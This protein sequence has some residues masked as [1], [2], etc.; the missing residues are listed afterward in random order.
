[1]LRYEQKIFS[2]DDFIFSCFCLKHFCDKYGVHGSRFGEYFASSRNHPKGTGIHQESL[3]RHV[4]IGGWGVLNREIVSF[5]SC[6]RTRGLV[7]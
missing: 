2:K 4:G 3:I 5:R 1:M 7:A 6:V